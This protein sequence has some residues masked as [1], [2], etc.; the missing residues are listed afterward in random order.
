MASLDSPHDVAILGGGLAGLTLALQLAQRRPKARVC[1]LE[2]TAHPAPDAAWKVGESTVELGTW[3]LR[4]VLGLA[5]YLDERHLPKLGLRF[6]L[7]ADRCVDRIE[8]RVEFGISDFWPVP[9]HQLDR[10]RL[11]S[12]LSELARSRGI[13]FVDR[14]SVRSVE[15]AGHDASRGENESHRV[16][17]ARDGEERRIEARWVVD[18]S[19][20]ASLL[21]RKL[22]LAVKA[23]HDVNAVWFRVAAEL[24]LGGWSS[25]EAWHARVAAGNRRLSTNHLM[26]Q[27][28][29]VWLIPLATGYTSVGIVADPAFHPLDRLNSF[30]KACE[31]LRAFEPLVADAVDA[32]QDRMEDFH[33]LKHFSHH[34]SRAYSENRWALVGEAG[35]FLDPFYSPGTDFIAIANTFAA[36]LI[37]RDLGGGPIRTSVGAYNRI[38][39]GMFD[40]WLPVFR[41]QYAVMGNDRVM[42]T[43]I[44]WDF[45]LYW[46]VLVPTFVNGAYTNLLLMGGL[47][48]VWKRVDDLHASMQR[49]FLEL[50]DRECTPPAAFI[51]P[52]HE[53]PLRDLHFRMLE[54]LPPAAF[55]ERITANVA[56]LEEL[57][58]RMRAELAESLQRSP[59][60]A[61]ARGVAVRE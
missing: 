3:Y 12:D 53:E 60:P 39:L 13:D 44:Y 11:E 5:D 56:F 27:G 43:K 23:D 20:R 58:A 28:Y 40:S 21:K 50:A 1:V 45:A 18:A 59:R 42:C 31:W 15:L 38:Y 16:T 26:G 14:A 24:D 55:R 34:C 37:D 7:S 57:A 6:F 41:G 2:R 30:E 19:G 54:E 61:P 25:D 10:G 22:G 32:V 33:A 36:D 9:S 17:F 8:E 51:D 4:H 52:L 46:G 48:E 29:W 49:T 35:S 47:Q